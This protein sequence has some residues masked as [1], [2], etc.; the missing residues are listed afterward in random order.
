MPGN[1][2]LTSILNRCYLE[3]TGLDEQALKF[4]I[5]KNSYTR[6]SLELWSTI[7]TYHR[8]VTFVSESPSK[9]GGTGKTRW[10]SE[11]R[12]VKEALC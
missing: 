3:N 11:L 8:A 12:A 5:S 4:W 10:V 7:R 9:A 2:Y 6:E 1:L